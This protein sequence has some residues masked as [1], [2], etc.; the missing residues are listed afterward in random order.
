MSKEVGVSEYIAHSAILKSTGSVYS[1]SNASISNAPVRSLAYRATDT[2]VVHDQTKTQR[3]AITRRRSD[4]SSVPLRPDGVFKDVQLS[5]LGWS[6]PRTEASLTHQITSNGGS[7]VDFISPSQYACVCS[8]G[9]RPHRTGTV[10]L[11]S[12]RW[13]NDCLA[14]GALL[15]PDTHV[16]YTPSKGQLPLLMMKNVCLYLTE[17]DPAKLSEMQQIAKLCGIRCLVSSDSSSGTRLSAVT[18]FIFHD[19]ASLNRRRDL[20]PLAKKSNKFIVS[21]KWLQEVYLEGTRQDE[22]LFDPS[23]VPALGD[24]TGMCTDMPTILAGFSLILSDCVSKSV[25]ALAELL[26]AHIIVGEEHVCSSSS[27]Y[28]IV[29][30]HAKTQC[31]CVTLREGWVQE[32]ANQKRLVSVESFLADEGI[33]AEMIAPDKTKQEIVWKNIHAE[34]L[35]S[36]QQA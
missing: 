6:D 11:V 32:C 8:D 33:D 16:T 5:L 24:N 3:A 26:G 18:H 10:L 12:Q 9:T 25:C 4:I 2:L 30:V 28:R 19:L 29:N 36:T 34:Q 14:H 15:A 22:S 27:C 20:L 13:V 23:A 35:A 21:F 31:K 1:Q 7:V 17:K